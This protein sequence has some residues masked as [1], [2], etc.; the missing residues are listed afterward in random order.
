MYQYALPALRSECYISSFVSYSVKSFHLEHWNSLK[1][2]SSIWFWLSS[3]GNFVSEPQSV[4]FLT[5][6]PGLYCDLQKGWV[7]MS[8]ELYIFYAVLVL[9]CF[10][11]QACIHKV[12]I[13]QHCFFLNEKVEESLDLIMIQLVLLRLWS[14]YFSEVYDRWGEK[15]VLIFHCYCLGRDTFPDWNGLMRQWI[16][17]NTFLYGNFIVCSDSLVL[18]R[19]VIGKAA[20]EYYL[21]DMPFVVTVWNFNAHYFIRA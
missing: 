13:T 20:G 4:F 19:W 18:F 21:S 7:I 8:M 6:V 14:W 12:T 3:L 11:L 1:Y 5:T 9:F 10:Q 16:Y 15:Q 2:I 17:L